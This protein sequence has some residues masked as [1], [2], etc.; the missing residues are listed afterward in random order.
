MKRILLTLS[1][2]S[3]LPGIALASQDPCPKVSEETMNG[4]WEAIYTRDTVRVFRLEISEG[5]KVILSQGLAH[6]NSFV[7]YGEITFVESGNFEI[8]LYDDSEPLKVIDSG[9][10]VTLT[11]H[12][13]LKGKGRVCKTEN[14]SN[15]VLNATLVMEPHILTPSTWE[16]R[17]IQYSEGT[18][19]SAVGKM[20]KIAEKASAGK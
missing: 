15:G 8:N 19:S 17:F 7:A 13:L 2:A 14:G 12:S 4:V 1:L 18:L 9:K 10:E 11:G 6:G 16:I 20:A 5:R 3:L